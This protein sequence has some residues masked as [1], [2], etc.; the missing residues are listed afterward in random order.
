MY[1]LE[2]LSVNHC[3]ETSDDYIKVEK[4]NIERQF[5]HGERVTWLRFWLA[6][7]TFVGEEAVGSTVGRQVLWNKRK[8]LRCAVVKPSYSAATVSEHA[9]QLREYE[10]KDP[11]KCLPVLLLIE[12]CDK[13]YL[14][15]MRN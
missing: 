6:E 10:E 14:D 13:E 12:D 1:S 9:V 7:N 11:E 2:I 5:Y 3:D 4:E 8:D 15:E